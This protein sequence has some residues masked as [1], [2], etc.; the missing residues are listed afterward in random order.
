MPGVI[1]K[2]GKRGA[3]SMAA[4]VAAG[5]AERQDFGTL[6]ACIYQLCMQLPEIIR[7]PIL[8]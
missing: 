5:V 2:I 8:E 7:R 4:S 1:A 3:M 6:E